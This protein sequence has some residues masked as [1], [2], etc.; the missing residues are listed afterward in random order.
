[1]T[2]QKEKSKKSDNFSEVSIILLE[3]LEKSNF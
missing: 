3:L 1:M 2:A